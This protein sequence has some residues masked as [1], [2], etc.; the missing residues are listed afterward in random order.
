MNFF[1]IWNHSSIN[2]LAYHARK[3]IVEHSVA[4]LLPFANF[5][6]D[7]CFGFLLN[8][9]ASLPLQLYQNGKMK[10]AKKQNSL[11]FNC[12]TSERYCLLNVTEFPH[13]M[14]FTLTSARASTN[15]QKLYPYV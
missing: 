14:T 10:L 2:P 9:A 15:L 7:F 6:K 13:L 3:K 4:T 12:N 11:K 8:S 1:H 5:P